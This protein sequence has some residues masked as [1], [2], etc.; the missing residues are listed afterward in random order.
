MTST[1]T[2]I[3]SRNTSNVDF[4]DSPGSSPVDRRQS[5]S[6]F[7]DPSTPLRQSFAQQDGV[8]IGIF[9]SGGAAHGMGVGNLAAEL[10]DAWHDEE[11][12]EEY[13]EDAP[14]DISFDISFDIR[15][16]QDNGDGP[17]AVRDSGV[18]IKSPSR[19]LDANDRNGSLTLPSP[20]ARG[21][22]RAGSEYD[23]S[24]YG[25]DSDLD[26][27]DM[28]PSLVSK[29]DAVEALARSGTGSNGGHTDDVFKRVADGLRDLGSQA[30][31]E[32]N[33]SRSVS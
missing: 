8:D 18:D 15:T 5:R 21:H 6:S 27:P 30:N 22:K 1:Y 13:Y 24:E 20:N 4:R 33:A 25:T 12:D 9:S 10:A 32:A 17:E 29:I 23:G 16:G 3:H 28:P 2:P 11:E 26:S 14:P 7:Q 31:V 19:R